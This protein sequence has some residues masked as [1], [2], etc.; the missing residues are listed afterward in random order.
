MSKGI[1]KIRDSVKKNDSYSAIQGLTEEIAQRVAMV[2]PMG[3]VKRDPSRDNEGTVIADHGHV[4]NGPGKAFLNPL[5]FAALS[6]KEVARQQ[7]G[8]DDGVYKDGILKTELRSVQAAKEFAAWLD[9]SPL[10]YGYLLDITHNDKNKGFEKREPLLNLNDIT[11]DTSIFYFMFTI[12]V[13]ED[14]LV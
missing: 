6:I 5:E 12:A 10:V 8:S 13:G 4:G 1:R 2:T 3:L 7:F 11:N 9:E 14:L